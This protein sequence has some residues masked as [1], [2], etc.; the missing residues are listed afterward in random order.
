MPFDPTL[1]AVRFGYGLPVPADAPTSVEA[2]LESLSQPDQMVS[3]WP[4]PGPEVAGEILQEFNRARRARDKRGAAED[5]AYQAALGAMADLHWTTARMHV[6]RALTSPDGF[7]ERL[8]AFWADHFTT[9]P[10]ENA[11]RFLPFAM[12]DQAIR[13]NLAG[14]FGDLLTAVTMHPAMLVYLDQD[15]SFGP[16][17]LQGKRLKRGLNENL[18][19]EVIE[20]HALGVG[21]PYSQDDVREM[22]ELLTGLSVGPTHAMTFEQRRAE[23]GDETVLGKTY[24]GEGEAPIRAVLADLAR[25]P[26]TAAHIARKLAVHFVADTPDESLVE[27][28]RAAYVATDGD[29]MA[30][31]GALLSHPAAWVADTVKARQPYDF[32]LT[33]LRALEIPPDRIADM[34]MRRFRRTILDPMTAMGQRF[35]GAPGPDGWPEDAEAWITPQGLAARITWAMEMPGRLK[36]PLPDPTDFARRALGPRASERLLWAVARAESVREGVGL[37]LVSPEFNRR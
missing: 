22:A 28:L 21:A 34:N 23:P 29:L 18:A 12:M 31:Y 9:A 36:N 27:A 4:Q 2:M 26:E 5:S 30:V 3:R 16:N 13:P 33:S 7:R 35:K 15:R 37:V 6:L 24:R 1:A 17:S 8:A 20:L 25:H 10:K 14:R 19:R 11:N 32:I